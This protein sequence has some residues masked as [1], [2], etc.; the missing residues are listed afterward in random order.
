M[1]SDSNNLIKGKKAPLWERATAVMV[2][3]MEKGIIIILERTMTV[4]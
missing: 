3:V 4:T 2:V 1:S